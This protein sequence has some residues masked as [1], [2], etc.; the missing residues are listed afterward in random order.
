[1]FSPGHTAYSLKESSSRLATDGSLLTV[2]GAPCMSPTS[3]DKGVANA[4]S[5]E[6][7]VVISSIFKDYKEQQMQ[8]DFGTFSSTLLLRNLSGFGKI[9]DLISNPTAA[10]KMQQIWLG[11]E[12]FY[13]IAR[14]REISI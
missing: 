3:L 7:T 6:I 4:V 1:M 11:F 13:Y 10:T 14:L 12:W 9:T 2:D 8:L 5:S